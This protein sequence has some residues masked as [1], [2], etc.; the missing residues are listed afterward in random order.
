M[1]RAE[2][3]ARLAQLSRSQAAEL[4]ANQALLLVCLSVEQL[5]VLAS[6]PKL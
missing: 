2:A 3:A 6:V 4:N 1:V 5:A